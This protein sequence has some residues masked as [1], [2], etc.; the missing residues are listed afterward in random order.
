ML[1]RL[2]SILVPTLVLGVLISEIMLTPFYSQGELAHAREVSVDMAIEGDFE[3]AIGR[4]EALVDIAP[5]DQKV[6]ADYISVLLSAERQE[7]AF[8]LADQHL[9][10]EAAPAYVMDLLLFSAVENGDRERAQVYSRAGLRRTDN[11]E[12]Y[13]IEKSRLLSSIGAYDLA[14][15]LLDTARAGDPQ[16]LPLEVEQLSLALLSDPALDQRERLAAL[17]TQY[18]QD[19]MIAKTYRQALVVHAR[20]GHIDSALSDLQQLHKQKPDD[21]QLAGDYLAVLSWAERYPQAL[22]VYDALRS[23]DL[24][25]YVQEAA[26]L[27]LRKVGRLDESEALYR[28]LAQNPDAMSRDAVIAKGLAAIALAR[29][30]Y[31]KVLALL[32]PLLD[33]DDLDVMDLRARAHQGLAHWLTAAEMFA[34]LM[35]AKPALERPYLAWF[36]TTEKAAYQSDLSKHFKSLSDWLPAANYDAINARYISLLVAFGRT[37]FAQDLVEEAGIA[38][39][40]AGERLR[41]E[42][43]WQGSRAREDGQTRKALNLYRFALAHFPADTDVRLGLALSY[44]ENGDVKRADRLFSA[45]L[46]ETDDND[47]LADVLYH[48][49]R[50]GNE[51]AAKQAL[52]KL[53]TQGIN[54]EQNLEY[55]IDIVQSGNL[56]STDQQRLAVLDE[57]ASAYQNSG[58]WWQVRARLLASAGECETAIT[59]L[60]HFDSRLA[61]EPSLESAAFV[62][63]QC[64]DFSRALAYYEE[65]YERFQKTPLW[66]AGMALTRV[67]L[68]QAQQALEQLAEHEQTYQSEPAFLMARAYAQEKLGE[69]DEALND[70]QAVLHLQP[71]HQ[72]AYVQRVMLINAQGDNERA[73]ALADEQLEWFSPNQMARLY[74]D[75]IAIAVRT[76]SE[77]PLNSPERDAW[78]AIASDKLSSYEQYLRQHLP[79]D[80]TLR[81]KAQW[82]RLIALH[83]AG[84]FGEMLTLYRQL[85]ETEVE[86]PPYVRIKVADAYLQRGELD[87]GIAMLE[88]VLKD[89]PADRGAQSLLFYTYLEN[90][91]YVLAEALIEKAI[92]VDAQARANL[93]EDSAESF[94]APWPLQMD[95]MLDAYKN[96]LQSAQ[97]KLARLAEEFPLDKDVKLKQALIH[98]WRAWPEKA[99]AQHREI[100]AEHAGLLESRIGE[101]H[102]LM[103]MRE[104]KKAKQALDALPSADGGDPNILKLRSDWALHN[105]AEFDSRVAF[106]KSDGAAISNSDLLIESYLFSEPKKEHYRWFAH[107]VHSS[108]ALPGLEG[109]MNLDRLGLGL[110]HRSRLFQWK[111]EASQGVSE[112]SSSGVSLQGQYTPD[113]YWSF[114]AAVHANSLD[115]PLRAMNDGVEGHSANLGLAYRWHENRSAKAG[116]GMVDFDDG[117]QRQSLSAAYTHKIYTSARHQISLTE[118]VYASSNS[119]DNQRL[120]F[121]PKSDSAFSA[122]VQYEGLLKQSTSKRWTH[123]L[124]VGAGLYRQEEHDSAFIW[125]LDYQQR[126]RIDKD[127]HFYYG[128]LHRERSYDGQGEGY[129]AL[130]AGINVRF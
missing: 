73:L 33:R 81:L 85:D 29:G 6:W 119:A 2:I 121:N 87:R 117:N 86:L 59:A 16:S 7:Q 55:W 41:Q 25:G 38:E 56:F 95:A 15:Y 118:S 72:G 111:A 107:Q 82:D 18:L 101:V 4:F 94:S 66:L 74:A 68:D 51:L 35:A 92:A 130:Y 104:Y 37:T 5:K 52:K 62:A 125:D 84:D 70:Y 116:V 112:N 14:R 42:L 90:E 57:V 93:S 98:R 69:F 105:K 12:E 8:A 22:L 20:N 26:A 45:L 75:E 115:V 114:S 129:N 64:G 28:Q 27:S 50:F 124:N 83:V 77:W 89:Y 106:G 11:A 109:D 48:F 97:E 102:A 127:L 120:Y 1:Q 126:W 88:A 91:Q 3:G 40:L 44:S 67:D 54:T 58:R 43:A 21:I 49:R 108:A 46:R 79:D 65:G 100:L 110:E 31:Q 30:H 76:A 23:P 47:I 19:L 24:K 61:S 39:G 78:L 80:Q 71:S 34:Q 122:T 96:D 103:D 113:D 128:F 9:D 17:Y 36:D 63:R 53:I 10:L 123:H 99:L 60:D 13:A 32:E